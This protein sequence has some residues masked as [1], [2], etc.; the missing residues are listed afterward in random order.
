MTILFVSHG[1]E[2]IA[3]TAERIYVMNRGEIFMQG[4]PLEIYRHY[5]D[6][7]GIGLTAPQ[8]T[9]LI[10]KLCGVNVC[11]VGQAAEVLLRGWGM[12]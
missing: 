12:C 9:K 8:V 4:A 2:D 5:K 1:M 11:T 10:D 7:E 3:N 6:L